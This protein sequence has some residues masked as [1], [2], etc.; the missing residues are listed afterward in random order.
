[1]IALFKHEQPE[2]GVDAYSLPV[3]DDTLLQVSFKAGTTALQVAIHGERKDIG[4]AAC[5]NQS[6][7]TVFAVLDEKELAELLAILGRHR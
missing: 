3:G 6:H 7:A 5:K 4:P 1:M 2:P